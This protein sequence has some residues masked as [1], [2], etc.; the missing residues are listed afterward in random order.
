[1]RAVT[2]SVADLRAARR[3]YE[4]Q[5]GMRLVAEGDVSPSDAGVRALWDLPAGTGGR[6]AWLEQP[7]AGSG[8]IRLVEFE[9]RSPIVVTDGARPYDH[10]LIKNLD[11]F[12]DDVDAAYAR[13]T[14][15]GVPFLAPPVCY[16]V[17]WG[18]GVLACEAHSAALEGVKLSV[19]RL[20]GAPRKAFGEATHE[21]P[22]TEVAVAAQVV[23]DHRAAV[24]FYCDA[25]DCVPAVDTAI[26]DEKL[27]AALRLPPGT[28]LRVCFIGPPQAV[29]GKIGLLAYEGDGVK[30]AR[31]LAARSR[32]P[33]RGAVMMSFE[34]DDVFHR[35]ALAIACGATEAAPPTSVDLL[36]FGRVR[37]SSVRSPDGL[38]IELIE[39]ATEAARV[40]IDVLD[41]A[42]L[43]EGAH[44]GVI[45]RGL[46]RIVLA[47]VK[48]QVFALEDRCPH[49]Q[50][51]LSLGAFDGCLLTCPWHGWA[52]DVAT[53][54]VR[55][56]DGLRARVLSAR[57]EGGRILVRVPKQGA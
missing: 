39:P 56:G 18:R 51:P 49:L 43:P 16:P 25:F 48:G 57:R 30:D 47:N 10:G 34:C 12:T 26:E 9:P 50:G 45:A 24:R 14:A 4:E 19:A 6:V 28:R 37:A 31:S 42:A 8:A 54:K 11:F 5:L 2:L 32:P 13:L 44:R 35:H 55:G 15:A 27:I 53:G 40:D 41:A 36:P 21:T 46:G 33:H 38:L 3:L 7:G 52:I 23:A 1:M 20:L 22:F 29:G 17:P